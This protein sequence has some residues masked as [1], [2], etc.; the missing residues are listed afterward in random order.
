MIRYRE[1]MSVYAIL[2]ENLSYDEAASRFRVKLAL[3]QRLMSKCKPNFLA[4]Y[5]ALEGDKQAK[6]EA[7]G[8]CL[9]DII[10]IEEVKKAFSGA[11]DVGLP[12]LAEDLNLPK[13]SI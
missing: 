7:I 13:K 10:T 2:E 8:A 9:G 4:Y 1:Q 6:I 12:E 5:K 3:V 11:K